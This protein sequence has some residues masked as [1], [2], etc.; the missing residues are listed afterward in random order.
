VVAAPRRADSPRTLRR[1]NVPR[2][3][4]VRAGDSGTPNALQREGGWLQVIELLDRYRTTDRWWT[5]Q[6]IART[7]Y[8]LLLEDGRSVTVFCDEIAGSWWE[9]RYG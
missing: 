7:Y 9:Q 4:D 6:P 5:E 2:R 3:V 8:G 1:L